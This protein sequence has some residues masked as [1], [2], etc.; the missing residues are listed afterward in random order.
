MMDHMALLRGFCAPCVALSPGMVGGSLERALT[1]SLGAGVGGICREAATIGGGR[2]FAGGRD[3][4]GGTSQ[5][6]RRMERGNVTGAATARW[7]G[8][9]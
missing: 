3:H 4:M 1:F 6:P 7:V 5:G 9:I 2:H 8:G